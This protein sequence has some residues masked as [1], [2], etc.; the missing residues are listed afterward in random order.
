MRKYETRMTYLQS[1]TKSDNQKC[2]VSRISPPIPGQEHTEH[3][4]TDKTEDNHIQP[5]SLAKAKATEKDK[6]NIFP[7]DK[8]PQHLQQTILTYPRSKDNHT[9]SKDN[10]VDGKKVKWRNKPK[11]TLSNNRKV[12]DMFTRVARTPARDPVPEP[13]RN[14]DRDPLLR[15][16]VQNDTEN[17]PL[18]KG[19]F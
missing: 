4:G 8:K 18:P 13:A 9:R 10:P 15:E 5:P 17:C 16:G 14:P 2:S 1:N 6:D 19:R 12:T 3:T 11:F 7:P